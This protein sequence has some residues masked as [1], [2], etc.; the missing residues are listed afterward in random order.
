M[1]S[2]TALV[3]E[4]NPV[5][6]ERYLEYTNDSD[7][8]IMLKDTL[9]EFLEKLQQE[10]FDLIVAEESI[11]PQ[12]IIQM[13]K[14]IGIPFL[15]STNTKNPEIAT[16]PRNFNRTE[17]LTVFDRLVPAAQD[18]KRTDSAKNDAADAN[19]L[20]SG[21]EDEEGE[22]FELTSDALIL[23]PGKQSGEEKEAEKNTPSETLFEDESSSENA[24]FED[25]KTPETP[26]ATPFDTADADDDAK[27][28]FGDDKED[29]D[30]RPEVTLVSRPSEDE[31]EEKVFERTA[32]QEEPAEPEETAEEEPVT[33]GSTAE[34]EVS[35]DDPV[36]AAVKEWLDKNARS[37]IKEVILEQLLSL[38]GKNND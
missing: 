18:E 30:F 12:A 10:Q 6:T 17:L 3:L 19:E 1:S 25:E 32:V 20:F 9:N 26:V 7:W 5:I 33:P 8:R 15:L 11:L 34:A 36:K 22:A 4:T 28:L 24:L 14:S 31:P 21:L 37:I 38:S 13:M 29:E 16:L 23:D 27:F 35:D 2:R